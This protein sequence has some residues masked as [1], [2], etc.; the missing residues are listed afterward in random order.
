MKQNTVICGTNLTLEGV[1]EYMT[2]ETP[3]T[4]VYDDINKL[5]QDTSYLRQIGILFC[6]SINCLGQ[7]CISNVTNV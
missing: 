5:R 3:Y 1:L 4:L 6:P 2:R 7:H